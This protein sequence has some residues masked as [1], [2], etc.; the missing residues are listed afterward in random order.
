MGLVFPESVGLGAHNRAMVEL[1]G[2]VEQVEAAAVAGTDAMLRAAGFVQPPTVHL[3]STEL[4]PP[5]I[6]YVVCRPFYPGADAA[7]AIAALGALPAAVRAE[8][9]LVCWEHSDLCT[10]LQLPEP[11]DAI[12]LVAVDADE[13][14]HVVGRHPAQVELGPINS[15]GLPTATP[16]WG[17][18]TREPGGRL[19]GPVAALLARWR[20]GR[21]HTD[22]EVVGVCAAMEEAGY[23]LRWVSREVPVSGP[24][25]AQLLAPLMA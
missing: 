12:G 21:A 15:D 1:D 23:R 16:D 17:P 18:V 4:D 2:W 14:G 24:S 19:P 5:Y 9:V 6:G 25:W 8:R 11:E 22:V 7:A 3:F 13:R 10:A 20:A